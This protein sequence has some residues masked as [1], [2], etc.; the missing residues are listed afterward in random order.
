MNHRAFAL[1]PVL[2][3]IAPLV[4]GFALLF[5]HYTGLARRN[6]YLTL[7][8]SLIAGGAVIFSRVASPA[9]G[10][11]DED[12][13]RAIAAGFSILFLV[14]FV[15]R[16]WGRWVGDKAAVEERKPGLPG[17]RAWFS[18]MNVFVGLMLVLGLSY[19]FAFP[20]LLLAVVI[21]GM[22]A[23]YPVIRLEGPT[24]NVVPVADDFSAE[25]EKILA[26]LEAGKLTPDESAE[27]LQA[28]RPN[29]ASRARQVPLTGGQRLM[30]IGA[31]L[32]GLGFF[33]PWLVINPGEEASRLMNQMQ[34][35]LVPIAGGGVELP[36]GANF[37]GMNLTTPTMSLS[38]GDIQ[39]GLGWVTLALALAAALLPYFATALDTE[40]ARTIR[41][42]CLGVGGFIV[43][44]LCTQ[45]LRFVG[46]GLILAAGGYVLEVA[47]VLR[48]RRMAGA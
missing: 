44:Y 7:F 24:P 33:L 2:V 4:I 48:E 18:P 25:R 13:F 31:A 23:A 20:P 41:V 37:P 15:L 28:L 3:V 46:V 10:L 17:V 6:A 32:V 43:L 9:H 30:L 16:L 26:M 42:L 29:S 8:G 1:I 35:S 40:T 36:S 5:R 19:G 14:A 27:L 21:S 34:L 38:G 47:G 39:R 22:L 45:N 12:I 11:D